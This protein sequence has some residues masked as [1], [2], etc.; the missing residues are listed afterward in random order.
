MYSGIVMCFKCLIVMTLEQQGLKLLIVCHE[1]YR[2]RQVGECADTYGIN[3][4][5][6]RLAE[7][8]EQSV[9]A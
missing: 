6:L 5:S 9:M 2:R 3:G 4:L 7:T 8:V 1:D